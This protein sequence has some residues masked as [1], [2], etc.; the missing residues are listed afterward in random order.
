M[1]NYKKIF[2]KGFFFSYLYIVV[3]L[4]IG[5]LS[6]PFLLSY[7]KA[8]YF[9]L[10]MLVYAIIL[11][12][13][14]I[15]F[16]LPESL[17]SI[18]ARSNDT[19]FKV[20]LIKKYFLLLFCFV[21]FTVFL[22]SCIDFIIDDWRLILGDVYSLNKETVLYVFFIL[23][24]FALLK[25]P[26]DLSLSIFIGM[27][28]V[29][30]EKIYKTIMVLA[31]FILILF[32]I[33]HEVNIINFALSAGIIDLLVSIFAFIHMILKYDVLNNTKKENTN[34][35]EIIKNG[36]IF[37]QLSIT[38]TIIWGIG[39]F[40]VSHMLSL[41]EVTIY[42]LTM[43]IY[44]YIYYAFIIVNSII[45]PL[46]GRFYAEDN[47]NKIKDIF[48][49]MILFF[50]FLGGLIWIGTLYFMK[51][52]IELWTGAKD[53][54]IGDFFVF[55][56]GGFFYFT[57]YI[58]SYITLLYSIGKIKNTINIRWKEVI[59]NILITF[60]SIYFLG[61]LG[62][63]I[64]IF[65]AIF[66]VS[67]RYY[68]KYV[69]LNTENK[70]N[71]DFTMHKKHFLYALFPNIILVFFV[72]NLT[73]SFEV[74]IIFFLISFFSY[75]LITFYILEFKYKNYLINLFNLKKSVNDI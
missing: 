35:I 26:F 65:C 55:F 36:S 54:Y 6:T 68:P 50:P 3:Y 13:N 5:L 28:D 37:F 33:K 1:S 9:A 71:L 14:N 58:N 27:N 8:D 51:D 10:L 56:M 17:S 41:H 74:K 69:I 32:V 46:Y 44:I 39:I 7:F 61:L 40:F 59:L 64:G 38:H 16:G 57:G 11:Y 34:L 22:F 43:K 25:I 42:S 52:V 29:Y 70:I 60:I 73:N 21:I 18:L 72:N 12:L 31:N 19:L 4:V 24:F 75:F 30:L 66:F 15:S 47:W 49:I 48:N 20:N 2:I 67:F 63:G 23:V 62:A 45:A 53:F